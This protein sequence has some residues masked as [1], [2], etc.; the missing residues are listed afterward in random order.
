M[1]KI[2]IVVNI[3]ARSSQKTTAKLEKPHSNKFSNAMCAT[4]VKLCHELEGAILAYSFSDDITVIIRNDQSFDTQPWFNNDIQKINSVAASIA[5]L[6]F[7]KAAI[8]VG[9]DLNE[10]TFLSHV[11]AVPNL[12]E[13]SNLLIAKQQLATQS[14]IGFAAYYELYK[15]Y[16]EDSEDILQ[17]RTLDE[18]EELLAEECGISFNEYPSVFKRGFAVYRAPSII[19]GLSGQSIK[20]KWIVNPDI[21]LFTKEHS[22]LN[23]LLKT[24]ADIVRLPV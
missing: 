4:T 7:S 20:N 15:K 5:T 12:T 6:E 13:V 9:M 18:K 19:G 24:G 2:P 1:R 8:S 23:N 17:G 21:P 10:V 22:F 16:G 11:F 14:A 3:N